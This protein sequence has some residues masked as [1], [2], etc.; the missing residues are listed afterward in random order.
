[1]RLIRPERR[2]FVEDLLTVDV[3]LLDTRVLGRVVLDR[4]AERAFRRIASAGDENEEHE[5]GQNE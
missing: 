3:A 2:L 4:D 5:A 1:M